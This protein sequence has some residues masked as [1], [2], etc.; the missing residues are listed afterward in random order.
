MLNVMVKSSRK[1]LTR[2]RILDVA[3][4]HFA[5]YGYRKASLSDIAR[6]L[7][8]VKG[9]LY[10]HLP[11]G[12]AEI[13]DAMTRR[14]RQKTLDAMRETWDRKA[15]A[16]E[17][18]RGVIRCK[19]SRLRE[20]AQLFEVPRQIGEEIIAQATAA[21][22]E[23]NLEERKL[24]E[25]IIE[26]G[27]ASGEFRVIRP[28]TATA[29]AIQAMVWALQVPE[30]YDEPLDEAS[31]VGLV[32]AVLELL[33]SGLQQGDDAGPGSADSEEYVPGVTGP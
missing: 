30:I 9:A 11:G 31:G 24:F 13:F 26:S 14:E 7:D 28:R 18:L 20:L 2:D 5:R 15:S 10:Y 12:K 8:V 19:I 4:Q 27:E 21:Q 22:Q 17:A 33:L 32:D 6:E 3:L 23:F 25:E 16:S 1:T 29:S